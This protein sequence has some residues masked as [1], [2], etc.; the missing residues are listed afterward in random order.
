VTV[1]GP[2]QAL[3]DNIGADAGIAY[4]A[5]SQDLNSPTV[6]RLSDRIGFLEPG[7]A[8]PCDTVVLHD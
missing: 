5:S 3:Q 2:E 8:C 6:T 7:P 4:G 1:A